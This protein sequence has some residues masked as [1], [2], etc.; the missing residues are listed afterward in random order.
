MQQSLNL[1]GETSRTATT[2]LFHHHAPAIFAFLRQHTSSREDAEDLLLEVFTAA[3]EQERFSL[4]S[5]S[6]QRKWLW[7][8]VRNKLVDSYRRQIRRPATAID[9]LDEELFADDAHSPEHAALRQEEHARLHAAIQTLSPLQ[10]KA[11][12]LRFANNLRCAEIAVILDKSES[13]VRM[14]LSRALNLLRTF[15][16]EDE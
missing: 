12:R 16:K 6:E 5:E 4:M 15:Y 8:V 1:D 9:A 10:Q 7:R 2:E 14:M 11:V 3:L 13:A